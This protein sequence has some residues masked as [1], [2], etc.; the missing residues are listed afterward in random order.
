MI[1]SDVR[2]KPGLAV[3]VLSICGKVVAFRYEAYE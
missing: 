2:N 3:E 1:Y